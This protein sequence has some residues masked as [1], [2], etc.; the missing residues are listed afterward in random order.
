VTKSVDNRTAMSIKFEGP[1]QGGANSAARCPTI[2]VIR[3]FMC[4]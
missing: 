4:S 1:R 2:R 3:G